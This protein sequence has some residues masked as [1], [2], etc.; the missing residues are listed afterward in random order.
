MREEM[1]FTYRIDGL[2]VQTGDII[3]TTTGDGDVLPGQFWRLL[4]RLV[5]G[6]VDHVVV[7]VGPGGRCV[8]AGGRGVVA[9]DVAGSTWQVG[10]MTRQRGRFSDA[11]YG[12][13]Y[14]LD[15][16]GLSGDEESRVRRRV[17]DY[18][19]AQVG[20]PYNLNYLNPHTEEAFYCSQ[21]AY[22]AYLREGIDLNT[23][24]GVPNLAGT[25]RIVF[26]Q[27]I[28]SG[29]RNERVGGDV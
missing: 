28:W 1:I 13:A 23:G 20:K 14:P 21:L 9:F 10:A 16:Q 17:A 8:E 12:V 18:C 6:A 15:G 4:G 29:C 7:Y 2:S 25:G 19:L 11:F 5:P 27:E 22:L 24:Q 26:P 3:C